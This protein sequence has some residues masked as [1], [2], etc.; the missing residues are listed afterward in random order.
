[1]PTQRGSARREHHQCAKGLRAGNAA[2]DL[3]TKERR[4]SRL[5][6]V[7]RN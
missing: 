2:L 6:A 5:S 7:W 1:L 4:V 3:P